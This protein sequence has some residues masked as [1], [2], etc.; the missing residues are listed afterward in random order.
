MRRAGVEPGMSVASVH[1]NSGRPVRVRRLSTAARSSVMW[2]TLITV[3]GVLTVPATIVGSVKPEARGS[4]TVKLRAP[5]VP[6]PGGDVT[7]VI[8]N[9]PACVTSVAETAA[10][11]LVLLTNVVTRFAARRTTEDGTKLLPVS[12]SVNAAP[13]GVALLGLIAV[14][15]GMGL[16]M[17]R[18]WAVEV[19]PLGP[20]V[21]TVMVSVPAAA[22]SEASTVAVNL[23]TDTYVVA[24]A[25]PLTC[26]TELATKFVP[27]AASVKGGPP[28]VTLP[29]LM[30]V[31]VCLGG[32]AGQT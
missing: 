6:P 27:V 11:S 25:L 32:L 16:T 15:N 18:P 26:T 5:D 23:V 13:P 17:D 30:P 2:T 20:G 28:T 4:L 12:V 9:V 3:P 24:R 10:W 1:A 7:T 8:W 22:M 21:K 19:P 29:G 31:S 14:R